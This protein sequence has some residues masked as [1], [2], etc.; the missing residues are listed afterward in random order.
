M[1]LLKRPVS[2][3]NVECSCTRTQ[4]VETVAQWIATTQ[5]IIC[6]IACPPQNN[7]REAKTLL[8]GPVSR[9]KRV[10][11]SDGRRLTRALFLWP[12]CSIGTNTHIRERNY[13]G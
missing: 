6:T 1:D 12:P 9:N 10:A 8:F 11:L 5:S 13:S 3:R 4:V 7:S 2:R